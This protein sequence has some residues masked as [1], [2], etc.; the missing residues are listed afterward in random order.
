MLFSFTHQTAFMKQ[1]YL[2][3]ESLP[4]D[5]DGSCYLLSHRI[6]GHRR[7]LGFRVMEERGGDGQSREV[8]AELEAEAL[9]S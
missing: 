1:I 5:H 3:S 6:V 8:V 7:E 2:G 9:P 4:Q